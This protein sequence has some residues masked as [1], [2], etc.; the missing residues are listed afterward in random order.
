MVMDPVLF[1]IY[2]NDLP[3]MESSTARL[4]AEDCLLYRKIRK[5]EDTTYL[6]HD[7]DSQR[8]WENEWL[9]QL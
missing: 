6:Q 7:L 1:L 9:M 5:E 3:E 2:I 4:F 8:P